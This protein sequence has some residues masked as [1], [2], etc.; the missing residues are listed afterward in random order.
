MLN[1]IFTMLMRLIID[2]DIAIDTGIGADIGVDIGS[3]LE[4]ID[5]RQGA[6]KC[7]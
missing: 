7:I 3:G 4:V 1:H 6:G 5:L 2:I